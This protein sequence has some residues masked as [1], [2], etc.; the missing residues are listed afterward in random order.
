MLPM[1]ELQD[2]KDKSTLWSNVEKCSRLENPHLV[3]LPEIRLVI[4]IIVYSYIKWSDMHP[5]GGYRLIPE[6]AHCL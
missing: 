4:C 5:R 2:M 1:E 3:D 6:M